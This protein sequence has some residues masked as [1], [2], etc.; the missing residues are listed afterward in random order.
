M[1]AANGNERISETEAF[2]ENVLDDLLAEAALDG[3]DGP[4]KPRAVLIEMAARALAR[5]VLGY[6]LLPEEAT[7]MAL[8][9]ASAI[10][11]EAVERSCARLPPELRVIGS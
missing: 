7:E 11:L 8:G 1:H 6:R 9:R 10:M 2:V 5:A 3:A 4:I